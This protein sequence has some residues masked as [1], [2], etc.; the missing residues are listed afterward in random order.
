MST[1]TTT[2]NP[3]ATTNSYPISSSSSSSTSIVQTDSQCLDDDPY[4]PNSRYTEAYEVPE[5]NTR[6]EAVVCSASPDWYTVV[7]PPH[8]KLRIT[9]D[10]DYT[11]G[12]IDMAM[13]FNYAW[14]AS[15]KSITNQEV[16]SATTTAEAGFFTVVH[17]VVYLYAD[18]NAP[19]SPY[20]I[21]FV[22]ENLC[23]N[24]TALNNDSAA[25]NYTGDAGC[26]LPPM[27]STSNSSTYSTSWT[28]SSTT[29]S[30]PSVNA[31]SNTTSTTTQTSSSST[32]T[33]SSSAS[34]A[35][36]TTT[37]TVASSPASSTTSRTQICQLSAWSAFSACSAVCGGG[38][39]TRTR[40]ILAGGSACAGQILLD[41]RPCNRE[42]CLA[43]ASIYSGQVTLGTDEATLSASAISNVAFA[44]VEAGLLNAYGLTL[45]NGRVEVVDAT[46]QS[47][48]NVTYTFLLYVSS[49]QESLVSSATISMA[50]LTTML[51][52]AS[53]GFAAV[54]V[55]E[56]TALV[57]VT[58]RACRCFAEVDA[59]RTVWP[60][61]KCGAQ[62]VR[63]CPNGMTGNMTRQC[64]GVSGAGG[65]TNYVSQLAPT[66][67]ANTSGC[68]NEELQNLKTRPVNSSNVGETVN[69]LQTLTAQPAYFSPQDVAATVQLLDN[70][71]RFGQ[72]ADA[73]PDRTQLA[74]LVRTASNLLNI[75]SATLREAASTGNNN[76]NND[77]DG[78][79]GGVGSG[80]STGGSASMPAILGNLADMLLQVSLK[81]GSAARGYVAISSLLNAL[82][83]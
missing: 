36:S 60:S 26:A 14:V 25:A 34:P 41:S 35:A 76:N 67:A 6:V 32:S 80:S 62:S 27:S 59:F 56:L 54:T 15:S 3:S 24:L 57:A 30:G 17:I 9:V 16:V 23:W 52:A 28:T 83:L 43:E 18:H 75:N 21:T 82:L 70:V 7:L 38:L 64:L 8:I 48:Q 78:T 47:A 50:S 68:R 42:L 61:A 66:A 53:T 69:R 33:S 37:T 73:A 4:E 29:T 46:A 2:R 55:S 79:N 19:L 39:Q 22:G 51:Q 5:N 63:R 31:T 12:D 49:E 40:T 72:R 11:L 13:A 58:E 77:N 20:S 81:D 71:V 74:S 65:S 45:V 44:L 10:Y 1:S